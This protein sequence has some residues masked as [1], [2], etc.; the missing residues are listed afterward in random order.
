VWLTLTVLAL[1][2]PEAVPPPALLLLRAGVLEPHP[3]IKASRAIRA[4]ATSGRRLLVMCSPVGSEALTSALRRGA[5]PGCRER[6][7]GEE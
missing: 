3:L 7:V 5:V 6:R 2:L 1:P 4:K